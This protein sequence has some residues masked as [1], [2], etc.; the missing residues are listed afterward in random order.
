VGVVIIYFTAAKMQWAMQISPSALA[1]SLAVSGLTG[2]A[3]GFFPARRAAKLDP[4]VALRH[5]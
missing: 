5:E 4:I 1:G 3:F 2:V